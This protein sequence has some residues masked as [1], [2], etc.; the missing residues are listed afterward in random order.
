MVRGLT[1]LRDRVEFECVPFRVL[2]ECTGY[3]VYSQPKCEVR[4]LSFGCSFAPSFVCLFVRSIG[5]SFA[6]SLERAR[7]RLFVRLF[8]SAIVSECVSSFI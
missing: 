6:R 5:R 7:A 8:V 1:P 3:S 2:I 4:F